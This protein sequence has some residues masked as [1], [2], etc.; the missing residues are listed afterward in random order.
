MYLL[1]L[2][3]LP[4]TVTA[5]E[6]ATLTQQQAADE[7]SQAVTMTAMLGVTLSESS[8]RFL[9]NG[10]EKGFW[11]EVQRISDSGGNPIVR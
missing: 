3:W 1:A 10:D 6:P 8:K 9:D 5:E 4:V 2:A 7:S 11:G